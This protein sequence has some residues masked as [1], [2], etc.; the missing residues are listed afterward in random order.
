MSNAVKRS[1][2]P[3]V[4][5]PPRQ[6]SFLRHAVVLK[7]RGVSR[8]KHYADIQAGLYPKPVAIGPR[9]VAYPD[10]EVDLLNAA[11]IAGKSEDEIRA[12]VAKLHAAR[13]AAL[14]S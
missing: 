3:T 13:G 4:F 7:R 9:A 2:D 14:S 6:F 10:Y 8:S 11:K 1:T 5:S 12:L